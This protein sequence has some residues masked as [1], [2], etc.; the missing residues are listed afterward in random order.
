MPFIF[1]SLEPFGEKE[2]LC[3]LLIRYFSLRSII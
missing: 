2:A 3:Q 1:S